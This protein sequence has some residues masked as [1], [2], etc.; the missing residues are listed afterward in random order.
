MW[1][2]GYSG[3]SQCVLPRCGTRRI[4]VVIHGAYRGKAQVCCGEIVLTPSDGPDTIKG[5]RA[6]L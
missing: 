2:E 3:T 6:H 5:F 4:L 1:R